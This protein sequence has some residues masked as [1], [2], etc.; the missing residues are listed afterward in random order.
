MN[1]VSFPGLGLSFTLNRVAFPVFGHAIYWYGVIIALGFLLGTSFCWKRAEKFGITQDQLLDVLIFA[2][3]AAIIGARLYF[4]VFYLDLFRKPNGS[5]DF[6]QMFRIHDGGLA[7]YGGIIFSL[8]TCYLV[9]RIKNFS[10][11]ATAD[12]SVFGFLI[13]QMIGRW[14]NFMN[15]E[16]YGSA[17][18]L[19]WR[20]GI[21]ERVN[22]A[23]QYTEVHPTFLYE[24]LWN[25]LGFILLFILMQKGL[26]KF[27]GMF[28]LLYLAWYGFGRGL[29]EGLR[30]DS[31]YLF[32][33][34]IRVS[35]MLGFASAVVALAILSFILSHH[36]NPAKMYVSQ[37][38]LE[39][40]EPNNGSNN[41]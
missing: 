26:R 10:F 32:E 18:M 28:L 13:G 31:L 16:A 34:G 39:R 36:P 29:I 38:N 20:M 2:T 1:T 12:L 24:S 3:P 7:I 40:E 35:Q 33:T 30:S 19:P 27:D 17:T 41:T 9:T 5:L 23:L 8:L 21:Y 37:C 6:I 22:G 14:G 11:L 25:L 15:V 4:I